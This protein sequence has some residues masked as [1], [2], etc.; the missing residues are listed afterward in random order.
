MNLIM[1]LLGEDRETREQTLWN[2]AW[3]L[4]FVLFLAST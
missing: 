4:M 3:L 1:N 2:A